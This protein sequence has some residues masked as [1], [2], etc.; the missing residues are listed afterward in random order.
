MNECRSTFHPIL[1]ILVLITKNI[2][3]DL[4]SVF[5]VEIAALDFFSSLGPPTNSTVAINGIL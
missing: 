1:H 5:P 3:L 4:F 2:Q